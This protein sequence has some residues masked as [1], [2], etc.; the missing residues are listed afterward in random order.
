M[1][2]SLKLTNNEFCFGRINFDSFSSSV[3]WKGFFERKESFSFS[4]VDDAIRLAHDFFSPHWNGFFALSALSFDD[5]RESDEN[6]I[7]KY[8]SIYEDL[9]LKGYLKVLSD[10]FESYLCGDI[11]LVASDV[12]IHFD[13]EN[14]MNVCRIMMAH[15]SVLGQVFFMINLELGVVIYPHEDTGF[16]CISLN[17]NDMSVDFLN[18]VSKND[19]FNVVIND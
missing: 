6:V 13:V 16:G 12:S 3:G 11:H 4:L 15:G 2:K 8:K 18:Y 14:F 5:D 7:N 9:K 17:K 1:E 10:N 19:N